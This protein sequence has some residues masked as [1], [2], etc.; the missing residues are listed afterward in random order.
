MVVIAAYSSAMSPRKQ[1]EWSQ[2]KQC[3]KLVSE[4]LIDLLKVRIC[5]E[6][7]LF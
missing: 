3:Q 5:H 6:L 7:L 4:Q 1:R 2:R